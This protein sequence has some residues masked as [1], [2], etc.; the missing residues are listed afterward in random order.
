MKDILS[1]VAQWKNLRS[2]A[3]LQCPMDNKILAS[4]NRLKNLQFLEL[5]NLVE[6]D[7]N[8]LSRQSFLRHLKGLYIVGDCADETI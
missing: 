6:A 1:L 4:L 8:A 7:R 5:N 2:V 3:L